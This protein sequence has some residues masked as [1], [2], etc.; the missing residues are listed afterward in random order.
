[1][2]SPSV[3]LTPRFHEALVYATEWHK[4]QARKSTDLPYI[5]HPLGVASLVLEAGGNEDEAI[6]GLLHDVPEDCGGEPRL[7]EI[8]QQFGSRVAEIVRACSDTLVED[9]EDK[10]PYEQRKQTHFD[11]LQLADDGILLV[12]A[13]DKLHNARAIASD[14]Q[15]HGEDLWSRFTGTKAQVIWYYEMMFG[16]L[17]KRNVSPTLL[18]PLANAM[19]IMKG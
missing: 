17:T 8:E 11:H 6:A 16:L 10:A 15:N 2:N 12:T 19:A 9:R 14:L 5:L 7:F 13:A 18:T 4:D 1:M 3:R